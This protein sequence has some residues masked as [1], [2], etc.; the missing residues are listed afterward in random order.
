MRVLVT[1]GA[2][3]IGSHLVR[4]LVGAGYEVA[5]LDDLRAGTAAPVGVAF[6]RLS[7]AESARAVA[8]FKPE[9]VVHLAAQ[10]DVRR[11]VADPAGDAETNIVGS[12]RLFDACVK[13]G[14]GKVVFASS[15]AVYGDPQR[16]PVDEAHPTLPQSPYGLAKLTVERYLALYRTLYGLPY[17]VL[18]YANVYGPGQQAEGDGAVVAV[19]A[20]RLAKGEPLTI[21]GDGRQTRDFIHVA[22]VAAAIERALTRGDDKVLNISTGE[23]ITV[24]RLLELM[25]AGR[26]GNLRIAHGPPRAGDIRRSVL[27]NRAAVTSLDWS[28]Q[29]QLDQGLRETLASWQR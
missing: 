21:D 14:V 17:T 16:L 27:S 9:R 20:A 26:T 24:L 5:V 11:S 12:L 6:H 28:P 7:L 29:L 3:F 1:G 25:T 18:R 4:R 13:H 22:D 15:A 8:D 10:I 19:F 23:E 2:G